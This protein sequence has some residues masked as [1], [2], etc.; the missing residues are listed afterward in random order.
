MPGWRGSQ[1]FLLFNYIST[2]RHGRAL[3]RAQY[4]HSTLLVITRMTTHP[5]RPYSIYFTRLLMAT[6]IDAFILIII[7]MSLSF[8]YKSAICVYLYGIGGLFLK[9]IIFLTPFIF[10][11]NESIIYS[12]LYRT[13]FILSP[14]ALFMFWYLW[15]ILFQIEGLYVDVS[16]GYISRFPHFIV[17]LFSILLICIFTLIRVNRKLRAKEMLPGNEK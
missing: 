5:I 7:C 14:F 6:V 13:I 10:L 1:S 16:F 3:K 17:Q 15:V 4:K 2:A 12:R 9:G 11:Q 8:D